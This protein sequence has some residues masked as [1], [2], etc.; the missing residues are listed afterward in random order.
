M[1]YRIWT[2][3]SDVHIDKEEGLRKFAASQQWGQMD[4]PVILDTDKD[5][6]GF[7]YSDKTG[8]WASL[9]AFSEHPTVDEWN[10]AHNWKTYFSKE[11]K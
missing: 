1:K 10:W 2:S 5:T 3:H 6:S 7:P 4:V 9:K 11:G 8:G